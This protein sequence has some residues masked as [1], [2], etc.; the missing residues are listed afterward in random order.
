MALPPFRS[1]RL[2]DLYI[3]AGKNRFSHCADYRKN[4]EA[5]MAFLKAA[6]AIASYFSL[7]VPH[8]P[9]LFHMLHPGILDKA[10]STDREYYFS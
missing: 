3:A 7:P 8:Q 4:L 9:T 2:L 1:H 5:D 6:S 10:Q